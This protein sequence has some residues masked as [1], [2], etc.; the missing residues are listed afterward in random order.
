V[1]SDNNKTTK[2]KRLREYRFCIFFA[3]LLCRFCFVVSFF[4]ILSSSL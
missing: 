4:N 1:D 2:V 3:F